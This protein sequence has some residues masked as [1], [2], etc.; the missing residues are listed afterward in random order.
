MITSLDVGKDEVIIFNML[1]ICFINKCYKRQMGKFK[2]LL[3]KTKKQILKKNSNY[4]DEK[5]KKCNDA[6]KNIFN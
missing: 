6:F 3:H 1:I 2:L 4:S 5:Q